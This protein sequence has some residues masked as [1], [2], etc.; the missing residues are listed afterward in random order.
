[1]Q[2]YSNKERTS[3][4]YRSLKAQ[5]IDM[6][7]MCAE[8]DNLRTYHIWAHLKICTIKLN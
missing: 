4:T 2:P 8:K 6:L 7:E 5:R 1:M 3:D